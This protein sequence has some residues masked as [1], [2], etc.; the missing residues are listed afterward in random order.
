MSADS[1][2]SRKVRD[3]LKPRMWVGDTNQFLRLIAACEELATSR[4]ED[5]TRAHQ[6][7]ETARKK[8]FLEDNEWLPK[9]QAKAAWEDRNSRD[10]EDE[11]SG[12]DLKMDVTLKIYDEQLSG[13]PRDV[14]AELDRPSQVKAMT[15]R[16]GSDSY[17]STVS[18]RTGF[19]LVADSEGMN[20]ITFG[21]S[22]D[23]LDFAS[24]K[25]QRI[26]REQRPWYFWM[27]R[28][29]FQIVVGVLLATGWVLF[30]IPVGGQWYFIPVFITSILNAILWRRIIPMFELLSPGARARG[31]RAIGLVVTVGAWVVAS[32]VIPIMI[33]A[34]H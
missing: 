21:S 23:W 20:V 34:Q 9:E 12:A 3:K 22:R 29:W 25:L 30:L 14:L 15:L 16:M 5:I 13:S 10:L 33:A 7:S 24:A 31:S 2:I 8:D 28:L 26:I 4:R 1:A 18:G 19:R 17:S 11:L 6:K 27:A 32:V